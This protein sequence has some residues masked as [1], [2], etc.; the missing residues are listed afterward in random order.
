M[1][2]VVVVVVVLMVVLVMVVVVVPL[3]QSATVLSLITF[4]LPISTTYERNN[5][6]FCVSR[7]RFFTSMKQVTHIALHTSVNF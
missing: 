2:V 5:T 4:P 6:A 3:S 7:P 1:V